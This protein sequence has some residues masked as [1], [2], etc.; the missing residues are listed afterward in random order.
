MK[1][2]IFAICA[3]LVLV[4]A[5][6]VSAFAASGISAEEQKLL[7]K[8]KASVKLDDGKTFEIPA[9]YISQAEQQLTKD[10][11][12]AAQISTLD[13]TLD[14]A[15]A[16]IKANNIHNAA[17]AKASPKYDELVKAIQKGCDAAGYI[18]E[19]GDLEKGAKIVKKT[20]VDMTATI[21]AV[22]ALVSALAVSV[23]VISKKNLIAAR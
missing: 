17:E 10:E 8:F 22:I 11:L 12:T 14:E 2:T 7:D 15:F 5:F 13:K 16:I 4:T 1:K 9:I 19:P 18:V 3:M 20:G 23:A 21:V 6:A